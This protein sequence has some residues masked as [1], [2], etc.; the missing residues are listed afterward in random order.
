MPSGKVNVHKPFV[1]FPWIISAFFFGSRAPNALVDPI[2]LGAEGRPPEATKSLK[3]P[4]LSFQ[5]PE[6]NQP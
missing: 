3:L 4:G 2:S 1:P 6:S 5:R